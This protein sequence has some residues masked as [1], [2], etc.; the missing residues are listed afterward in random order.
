MT[1]VIQGGIIMDRRAFIASSASAVLVASVASAQIVQSD[2]LSQGGV[3]RDV[4][5]VAKAWL[6]VVDADNTDLAWKQASPLFQAD[7]TA[8]EWA[9]RVKEVRA[10]FGHVLGRSFVSAERRAELPGSPP[11]R[12]VVLQFSTLGYRRNFSETVTL[13]GQDDRWIVAGFFARSSRALRIR[14]VGALPMRWK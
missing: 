1:A 9:E 12:Y 3:S 4:I 6:E 2:P 13:Q 11:G 7:I 10:A 5:A 8:P 14:G